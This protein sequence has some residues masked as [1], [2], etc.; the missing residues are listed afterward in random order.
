MNVVLRNEIWSGRND[1]AKALGRRPTD[2]AQCHEPM[3]GQAL[4]L[5]PS[6]SD[7]RHLPNLL[8][9]PRHPQTVTRGLCFETA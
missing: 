8:H 3:I 9:R 1:G 2:L 5:L 4:Y 7:H 6:S